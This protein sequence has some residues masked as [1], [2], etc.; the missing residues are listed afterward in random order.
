MLGDVEFLATEEAVAL[1]DHQQ[2][3]SELLKALME[4]DNVSQLN[5]QV[6]Y[7]R[8][9]D[10]GCRLAELVRSPLDFQQR[11]LE[12]KDPL[13]R[14]DAVEKLIQKIQEQPRE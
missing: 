10:V 2:H 14:V 6:D 13:R 11:L 1:P 5:L 7:E 9:T 4:H 3:L 8:A 12:M